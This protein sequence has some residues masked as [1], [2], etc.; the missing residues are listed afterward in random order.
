[1]THR[2]RPQQILKNWFKGLVL[3]DLCFPL[4]N[5]YAK[6]GPGWR[7]QISWDAEGKWWI[8]SRQM[9]FGK[10][11]FCNS[12]MRSLSNGSP[13]HFFSFLHELLLLLV[14]DVWKAGQYTLVS[15]KTRTAI[16][17]IQPQCWPQNHL[18]CP[19]RKMYSPRAAPQQNQRYHSLWPKQR[20]GHAI[21]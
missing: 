8:T 5:E 15:S 4:E 11:M 13:T 3:N 17:F 14:A 9:L 7:E 1:M 18:H 10:V 12:I 16:K 6:E 21:M 19:G 20:Q 2:Q